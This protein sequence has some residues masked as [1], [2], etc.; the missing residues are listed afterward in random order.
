MLLLNV[1][2]SALLVV[3]LPTA[4]GPVSINTGCID[5]T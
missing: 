4:G 1:E 3:L 2:A 5:F